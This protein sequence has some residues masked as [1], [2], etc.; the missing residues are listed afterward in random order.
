MAPQQSARRVFSFQPTIAEG[1]A[2]LRL[3][4][5]SDPFG[6][7]SVVRTVPG[8]ARRIPGDRHGQRRT[9]R[10][11]PARD[12]L[13]ADLGARHAQVSGQRLPLD[14]GRTAEGPRRLA[15]RAGRLLRAD[16]DDQLPEH[17]DPGIPQGKRPGQP[18]GD[19]ARQGIARTRLREARGVRGHGERGASAPEYARASSG[20][21]SS[22]RTRR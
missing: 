3:A 6:E 4:G 7:D 13:A 8:R 20:S 2:E 19:E 15:P 12:Y 10:H 11:G 5:R 22:R 9:R 18:D 14:A 21:A 16:L 17:A 1:I